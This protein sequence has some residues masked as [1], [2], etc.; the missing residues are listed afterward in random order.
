[1]NDSD[2]E[3]ELKLQLLAGVTY[4]GTCWLFKPHQV[5]PSNRY[6]KIATYPF[7]WRYLQPVHRLAYMV[8]N[9]VLTNKDHVLHSCDN[10]CC[11][12][13]RHLSRGTHQENMADRNTKGR[14]A[15]GESSGHAK[16][17]EKDVSFIRSSSLRNKELSQ[18][19]GVH[20]STISRIRSHDKWKHV[21]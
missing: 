2:I 12:N 21:A 8:W 18:M 20:N 13:P 3:S 9:G 6:P 4:S 16:L 5:T 19:F 10:T 17:T 15:R 14:Q 7:G 11:I 1:M